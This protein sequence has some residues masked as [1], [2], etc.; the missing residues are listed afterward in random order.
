MLVEDDEKT[1]EM[2]A[3]TLEKTGWAVT[4]AGNGREALDMMSAVEP[5][6]ILLDLMMPVM[7]GF[8]F[9]AALRVRPKWQHIPVIVITAKDL[10]PQDRAQ[11][12]GVV[13]DV[14]EKNA[15]TRDDLLE[16][17]REAVASC[18]VSE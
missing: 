12:Q 15:Y 14:L 10:T 18:N 6:L 4:Q 13:E 7:D 16:R 2:M 9:L 17:V 5:R 11:L 1:R 8:G 3:R